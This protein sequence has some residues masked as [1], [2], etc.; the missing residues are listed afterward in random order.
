MKFFQLELAQLLIFAI[1]FFGYQLMYR[2]MPVNGVV[3]NIA[4]FLIIFVPPIFL[5]RS[6]KLLVSIPMV[7][8]SC[9][10]NVLVGLYILA[11]VFRD[12]L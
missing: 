6:E 10:L 9:A 8:A 2:S 3:N 11:S 4:Y 12:G 7:V 1:L 5:F